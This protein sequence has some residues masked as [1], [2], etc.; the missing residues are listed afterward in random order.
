MFCPQ[1]RL[2][3]PASGTSGAV[4]VDKPKRNSIKSG[5][6][7][8]P[9]L[10]PTCQVPLAADRIQGEF[11]SVA[12][13]S[14]TKEG[15]MT[16]KD[17]LRETANDNTRPTELA[18]DDK[19]RD[20]KGKLFGADGAGRTFWNRLWTPAQPGASTIVQRIAII[21]FAAC[22]ASI[23]FL[24][25]HA[26]PVS[27]PKAKAAAAL[28]TAKA[29][30]SGLS[31]DERTVIALMPSKVGDWTRNEK[32][33]DFAAGQNSD[34]DPQQTTISTYRDG[35]DRVEVWAVRAQSIGGK[36][37]L[38]DFADK[39]RAI[40]TDSGVTNVA[41][42]TVSLCDVNYVQFD[43]SPSNPDA[44]DTIVSN[45]FEPNAAHT[46]S[47]YH[48]PYVLTIASE[49]AEARDDFRAAYALAVH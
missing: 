35:A 42:K 34:S 8:S 40:H 39:S 18:L 6:W 44:V 28:S 41:P 46:I 33:G 9:L 23:V 11:P 24:T 20:P 21:S 36:S 38:N 16:I 32:D 45:Q 14:S 25:L 10:C 26:V 5:Q 43:Y 47:W 49:S 13:A 31:A 29:A 2:S 4:N 17:V 19:V 12:H 22:I 30:L 1:C 48:A 3:W 27:K 7:G 15:S 37:P